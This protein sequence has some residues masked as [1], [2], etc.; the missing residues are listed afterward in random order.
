[1]KL[2][3]SVPDPLWESAH[4]LRPDLNPS[5][6]V[7]E[8][9]GSWVRTRSAT[10]YPVGRP[11]EADAG[12]A[13]ARARMTATARAEFERGYLAAVT[14][15][16]TLDWVYL[17]SLARDRFEVKSWAERIANEAVQADMG[18]I[19][20]DWAPEPETVHALLKALGNIVHPFGDDMFA[21]SVPYLRGFTQAMR[22]LWTDAV[23][24]RSAQA[25]P[26]E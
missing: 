18:N 17:H 9:L 7:Q 4:E 14:C 3:V 1:M 20:R 22:D 10:P 26:D 12:F 21:P 24:G 15:A 13:A 6:L 16:E 8:A 23:E 19:P 5:A 25:A 2:S 11:P